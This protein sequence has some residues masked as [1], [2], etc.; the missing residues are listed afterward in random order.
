M[1]SDSHMNLYHF[2]DYLAH[3]FS[4]PLIIYTNITSA[5]ALQD[6]PTP[7]LPAMHFLH[8]THLLAFYTQ[9]VNRYP[10]WSVKNDTHLVISTDTL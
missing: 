5:I 9:K 6:Y 8:I 1:S 4:M 2:Y 10:L 3:L 7:L